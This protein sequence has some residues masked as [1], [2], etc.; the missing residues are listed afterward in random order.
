M[1]KKTVRVKVDGDVYQEVVRKSNNRQKGGNS[2]AE[3]GVVKLNKGQ[4]HFGNSSKMAAIR[5]T[6]TGTI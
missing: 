5:K 4:G 1:L 2:K 3:N 6:L